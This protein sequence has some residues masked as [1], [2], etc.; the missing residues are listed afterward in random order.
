M[1]REINPPAKLYIG[2]YEFPL[3]FVLPS[4]EALD[5][6]DGIT[7]LSEEERGIWLSEALDDRK[8]M[9]IALH[10][11]THAIDWAYDIS[12]RANKIRNADKR[13]E[14]YATQFGIAFSAFWLDNPKFIRWYDSIARRIKRDRTA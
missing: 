1:A 14:F 9:E 6:A 12:E 8:L 11:I 5:G 7:C 10:E 2:T 4:D 3:A 13:E